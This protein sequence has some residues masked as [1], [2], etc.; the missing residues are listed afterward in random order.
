MSTRKQQCADLVTQA[1][2]NVETWGI[3][4]VAYIFVEHAEACGDSQ[5]NACVVR[6]DIES[7]PANCQR[8]PEHV[9]SALC[10]GACS[11]KSTMNRLRCRVRPRNGCHPEAP[12]MADEPEAT[13]SKAKPV[14]WHRRRIRTHTLPETADSSCRPDRGTSPTSL[15][16][17]R[18]LQRSS[19]QK[20]TT[21]GHSSKPSSRCASLSTYSRRLLGA[22]RCSRRS[23][24]SAC[25]GQSSAALKRSGQFGC[26]PGISQ[27]A[28]E[29]IEQCSQLN[30]AKN[31]C[32]PWPPSRM[33]VCLDSTLKLHAN[34]IRR[35]D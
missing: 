27:E 14:R 11:S 3:V 32:L 19:T 28:S 34:Q 20:P 25:G 7:G 12:S 17:W 22:R 2:T 6:Y 16:G 4:V 24:T 35:G 30:D 9:A 29:Y 1:C 31:S 33:Y 26:Q 13:S 10:H 21:M 15:Q 23:R 18:R 5:C 8:N